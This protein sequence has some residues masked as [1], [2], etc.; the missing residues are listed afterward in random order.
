MSPK[1]HRN[2]DPQMVYLP[3]EVIAKLNLIASYTDRSISYVMREI[4][5]KV[6]DEAMPDAW[7]AD[8]I[9]LVRRAQQESAP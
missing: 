7:M 5:T 2:L 3:P 8:F 9:G 1:Q 4:L 6:V